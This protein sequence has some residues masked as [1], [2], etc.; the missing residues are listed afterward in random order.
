MYAI[1][2]Y[3]EDSSINN[4]AVG[5]GHA[6]KIKKVYD[7][8]AKTGVPVVGIYDSFGAVITDG[9]KA[10]SAYGELLMWVSNLSGVV[11]QI[12]VIAGT[13]AS[14][15]AM[16]ATSADFVVMAKDAE[17]FITPNSK[18]SVK[19][20]SEN[21]AKCGTASIVCEDD[22]EAVEM[23]KTL[24]SK[25]PMNN[26]SALPVYEFEAPDCEMKAVI[27]SYSI[28]YTKLYD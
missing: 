17:L 21:S 19:S 20:Y 22:K 11:P 5:Q 25:L 16:L 15:S 10:L 3:Y 12:S 23:A 6:K 1:R 18:E 7:L 28:H 27:T 13:C 4:G 9:I 14:S 8:A 26:L 24:I 2:S